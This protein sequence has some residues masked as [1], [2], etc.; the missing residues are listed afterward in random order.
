MVEQAGDVAEVGAD[1]VGGEVALGDEVALVVT[2]QADEGLG[3]ALARWSW[4]DASGLL[5][6]AA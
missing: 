1:G 6:P 4:S 3:Q 5:T 2:E